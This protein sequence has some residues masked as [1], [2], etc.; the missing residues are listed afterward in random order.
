M[1]NVYERWKVRF[2]QLSGIASEV[3]AFLKRLLGVL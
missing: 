3:T 1:V 2:R